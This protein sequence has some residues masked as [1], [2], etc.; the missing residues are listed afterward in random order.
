MAKNDNPLEKY[1]RANKGNLIHK[2]LHYFDIYDH[3]FE[4]FR[5]KEVV[6]LEF[7]VAHGGSLQMWKNYF[8]KKAR[9]IGVDIDPTCSKLVEKQVEIYI[10]SQEDSTFLK[11]L[12]SDIGTVDI[13]IDDG[14]HTVKQQNTTFDE[15]YSYVRDGG[16]YLVEDLHTNYWNE[17]GGGLRKQGTFIERSKGLIDELY[18][19]HSRDAE[20][21]KVTEFTKT[22]PSIHFYDSIIVFEKSTVPEPS[23]KQIGKPTIGDVERW[24]YRNN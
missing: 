9:I 7:G 4:R 11:K 16:V 5:D 20:S 23:H 24:E 10:G 19:W 12:M 15:V 6:I 2:W 21:L 18:A 17:F 14:G 8:G 13:V 3:H 1:F 22:T